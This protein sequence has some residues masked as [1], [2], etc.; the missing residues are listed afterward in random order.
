MAPNLAIEQTPR[1]RFRLAD[2]FLLQLLVA[3]VF[4]A[5]V[6]HRLYA[7][8]DPQF[9]VFVAVFLLIPASYA[10]VF[11]YRAASRAA[12]RGRSVVFAAMRRGVLCALLCATFALG[13][14]AV[15]RMVS[16]ISKFRASLPPIAQNSPLPPSFYFGEGVEL[17]EIAGFALLH[18]VVFGGVA[19]GLVGLWVDRRSRS[20]AAPPRGSLSRAECSEMGL[21]NQLG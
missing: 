12:R 21:P 15:V 1:W 4:L 9:S 11:S 19:G 8:R 10:A 16:S 18:Y 14:L 13:P 3:P 5:P 7:N 17:V 20:F 6:Y 2:C